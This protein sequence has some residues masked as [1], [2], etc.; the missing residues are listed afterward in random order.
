MEDACRLIYAQQ[1]DACENE[2]QQQ[3]LMVSKFFVNF[4]RVSTT[5]VRAQSWLNNRKRNLGVKTPQQQRIEFNRNMRK[6][7]KETVRI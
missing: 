6:L 2:V 1:F 7:A 3:S 4:G 5:V